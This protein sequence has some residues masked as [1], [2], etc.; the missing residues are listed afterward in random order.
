MAGVAAEDR[1]SPGG[2]PTVP[3][4]DVVWVILSWLD[5]P[6]GWG[7]AD[8][9]DELWP[10]EDAGASDWRELITAMA[11]ALERAGR[12]PLTKPLPLWTL[13][14]LLKR[15]H[16]AFA[17]V[18]HGRGDVP[19]ADRLMHLAARCGNLSA[20]RAAYRPGNVHEPLVDAAKGGHLEALR[21]LHD[22][23]ETRYNEAMLVAAGAG[24]LAIVRQLYEWGGRA[25]NALPLAAK[26]GHAGVVKALLDW[27][28]CGERA[29]Y[30]AMELAAKNQHTLICELL[31]NW[32]IAHM[33]H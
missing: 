14:E 27:G 10:E 25:F 7:L 3:P 11:H 12:D 24:K 31:I 1:P 15:G 19:R 6:G 9:A 8:A 20:I 13:A 26:N 21:L 30:E 2:A 22:L 29:P 5:V 32:H 17:V 4:T 16:T 33:G 23:G 28:I 18:R